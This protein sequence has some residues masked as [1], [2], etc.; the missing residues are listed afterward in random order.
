VPP[1]RRLRLG[2]SLTLIL[3]RRALQSAVNMTV[4]APNYAQIKKHH[5]IAD[6]VPLLRWW[7]GTYA[8]FRPA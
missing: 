6:V 4:Q 8:T 5:A 1:V 3:S 2:V 7:G